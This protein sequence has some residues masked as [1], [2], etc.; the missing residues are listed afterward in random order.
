MFLSGRFVIFVTWTA[1]CVAQARFPMQFAGELE[2]TAKRIAPGIQGRADTFSLHLQGTDRAGKHWSINMGILGGGVGNTS[3]FT[4]DFD[5]DGQADLLIAQNQTT[6]PCFSEATINLVL[7]DQAGRPLPWEFDTNVE[8][9]SIGAPPYIPVIA[10]DANRDRHAE[11]VLTECVGQDRKVIAK[12]YEARNGR[13]EIGD[14][15]LV[16]SYRRFAGGISADVSKWKPHWFSPEGRAISQLEQLYSEEFGCATPPCRQA[17]AWLSGRRLKDWPSGLIFDH[18]ENGRQ[19]ESLEVTKG[20]VDV[21]QRGLSVRSI[22]DRWLWVDGSK[23]EDPRPLNVGL[24]VVDSRRTILPM[25]LD[26]GCREYRYGDS[27]LVRICPD[28]WLRAEPASEARIKK[29]HGNRAEGWNSAFQHKSP[30]HIDFEPTPDYA[31]LRAYAEAGGF[32]LTQWGKR[33]ALHDGRGRLVQW[34]VGIPFDADLL[35]GAERLVFAPRRSKTGEVLEVRGR[36]RWS[37]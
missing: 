12:V 6:G 17:E 22:N 8:T 37:R 19:I 10:V 26:G 14:P 9:V 23:P 32:T 30:W 5:A 18:P 25:R 35:F 1:C 15:R 36:F 28:E 13:L 2:K 16:N 7:F 21:L 33:F 11:F 3:V 34:L 31:Q 29:T 20:L 24:E 4:G 27:T